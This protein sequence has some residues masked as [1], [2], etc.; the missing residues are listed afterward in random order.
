[1]PSEGIQIIKSPIRA[2]RANAIMERRI[3]SLRREIFDRMLV[4]N[5]GHLRRVLAEYENHINTH[6]PH[7]SLAQAAPLRALPQPATS[8][9]AVIRRDRLSGAI[10][11]YRQVDKG[12]AFRAPTAPTGVLTARPE[13]PVILRTVTPFSR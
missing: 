8:D 7:R 11:E 10:H 1:M 6:R 5:A 12:A 9:I 13:T 2:P 3:G 4:L